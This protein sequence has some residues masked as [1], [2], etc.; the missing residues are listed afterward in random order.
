M[1][2]FFTFLPSVMSP[3]ITKVWDKEVK[4]SS[5]WEHF[6][7]TPWTVDGVVDKGKELSAEELYL[8]T[9]LGNS[10][11]TLEKVWI[12][13]IDLVRQVAYYLFDVAQLR[14]SNGMTFDPDNDMVYQK[15]KKI[16]EIKKKTVQ[17][18]DQ[19][20]ELI[21]PQDTDDPKN[22]KKQAVIDE[23]QAIYAELKKLEQ[24][25]NTEEN[26]VIAQTDAALNNPE[27]NTSI[28]KDLVS[29]DN[30]N[31]VVD[32]KPPPP[33][34]PTT[35]P[36][37]S[38]NPPPPTIETKETP[39][40]IITLSPD[41]S[42]QD[43]N[44]IISE[45]KWDLMFY[46]TASRCSPCRASSPSMNQFA[47]NNKETIIYKIEDDELWLLVDTEMINYA[48]NNVA[49]NNVAYQAAL[50]RIRYLDKNKNTQFYKGG[51]N[52]TVLKN[53]KNN[54]SETQGV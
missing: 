26:S 32:K 17:T 34:S 8:L 49:Y 44:K 1:L 6:K 15:Y 12:D 27:V 36:E 52:E 41:T 39:A 40:N 4:Y 45:Q 21:Y 29:E 38:D 42:V 18:Y 10:K 33:P 37:T 9:D 24:E 5:D 22:N 35:T 2:I 28:D 7:I 53:L 51:F 20:V 31:P 14:K 23:R 48:N 30:N 16:A 50:P 11:T 46:T 43:I 3:E 13:R 47:N 25:K 19:L 54:S